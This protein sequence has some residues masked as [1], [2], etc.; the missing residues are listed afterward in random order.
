MLQTLQVKTRG[1]YKKNQ[2]PNQKLNTTTKG[3]GQNQRGKKKKR[4]DIE[5]NGGE[6]LHCFLD[7]KGD[8]REIFNWNFKITG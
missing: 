8:R 4:I 5:F 7:R 2:H 6:Y 3:M 1:G